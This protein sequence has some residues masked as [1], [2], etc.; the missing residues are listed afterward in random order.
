MSCCNGDYSRL[1]KPAV[2]HCQPR[3]LNWCFSHYF[4]VGRAHWT[5]V[6]WEK[7][8]IVQNLSSWLIDFLFYVESLFSWVM[9]YFPLLV[10]VCFPALLPVHLCY[11]CSI[12]LLCSCVPM[13]FPSLLSLPICLAAASLALPRSQCFFLL[14]SSFTCVCLPPPPAPHPLLE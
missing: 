11:Q 3:V 1:E 6:T 2:W 9:L 10:F 12:F 8:Y 14:N 13:L 5:K 7:Y 4:E